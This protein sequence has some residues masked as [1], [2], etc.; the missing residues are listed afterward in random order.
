M[1]F[2]EAFAGGRIRTMAISDSSGK[3]AENQLFLALFRLVVPTLL[4]AILAYAVSISTAQTKQSEAINDIK[5]SIATIV[6][7]NSDYGGRLIKVERAVDDNRR[8][9]SLQDTRL[10]VLEAGRPR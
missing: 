8:A 9:I 10:S 2:A 1:Q 5:N 3:P 7:Q 6:Q 4:G